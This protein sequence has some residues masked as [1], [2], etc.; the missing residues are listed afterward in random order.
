MSMETVKRRVNRTRAEEFGGSVYG[1][2][3]VPPWSQILNSDGTPS[4]I[5]FLMFH[6]SYYGRKAKTRQRLLGWAHPVLLNMLK[7]KKADVFVDGTFRCV[8]PQ[9]VHH[10]HSV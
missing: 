7:H 2:I 3:E 1:Q 6:F 4:T 8:P 5:T 10:L 9:T